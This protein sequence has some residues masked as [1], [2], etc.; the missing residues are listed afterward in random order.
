[1]MTRKSSGGGMPPQRPGLFM[2]FVVSDNY[3]PFF[4][5]RIRLIA[6]FSVGMEAA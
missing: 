2:P 5:A 1:M 6:S 4:Q 3:C